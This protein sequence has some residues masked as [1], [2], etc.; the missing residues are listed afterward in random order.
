[1]PE[2][3][4]IQGPGGEAMVQTD[5]VER[6]SDEHAHG[7]GLRKW[8]EGDPAD[9]K[10]EG[11]TFE[12]V[13]QFGPMA[14][15]VFIKAVLTQRVAELGT[16]PIEVRESTGRQRAYVEKGKIIIEAP[17]MFDPDKQDNRR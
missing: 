7:L 4:T 11:W 17:P 13:T 12:D 1:M 9:L 14:T 2:T 10:V 8:K 16:M 5:Y 15:S 6:G 3:R